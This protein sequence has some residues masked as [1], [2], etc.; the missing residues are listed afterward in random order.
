MRSSGVKRFRPMAFCGNSL[1]QET[2]LKTRPER[3]WW[4]NKRKRNLPE[5]LYYKISPALGAESSPLHE[6]CFG[7][8]TNTEQGSDILQWD[9]WPLCLVP[10][11]CPDKE[12]VNPDSSSSHTEFPPCSAQTQPR[13]ALRAFI[14]G[15]SSPLP[16]QTQGR[17]SATQTPPHFRSLLIETI[18]SWDPFC[19]SPNFFHVE[20]GALWGAVIYDVFTA[21]SAECVCMKGNIEEKNNSLF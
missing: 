16:A 17:V 11:S 8:R 3:G 15:Q 19:I 2:S 14:H 13:A 12:Q 18:T 7:K 4:E 10:R 21:H 5:Q 9:F 20:A 6:I 1:E